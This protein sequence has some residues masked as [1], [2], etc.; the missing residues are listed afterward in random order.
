M[1]VWRPRLLLVSW[2]GLASLIVG[3]A[4]V[5]ANDEPK[6]PEGVT[7]APAPQGTPLPT[8]VPTRA[9]E[10]E[11]VARA[12]ERIR[13]VAT[14]QT[15]VLTYVF[16][17]YLEDSLAGAQFIFE[18][19]DPIVSDGPWLMLH[20]RSS[21]QVRSE[22]RWENVGALTVTVSLDGEVVG[23][24]PRLARTLSD[25]VPALS[26]GQTVAEAGM[27]TTDLLTGEVRNGTGQGICP[28][29][30]NDD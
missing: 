21:I 29:G 23:I 22:A 5:V 24:S 15:V 25:S 3:V 27:T 14:T 9:L 30:R 19:S 16:P 10:L 13:Q 11:T 28:P 2:A 7:Y 8:L 6:H 12:D 26:P 1:N 17:W 18:F 20:C 4:A